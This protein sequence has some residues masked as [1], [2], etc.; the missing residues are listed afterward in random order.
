MHATSIGRWF[1]LGCSLTGL[2]VMTGVAGCA[3]LARSTPS[4]TIEGSATQRRHLAEGGGEDAAWTWGLWAGIDGRFGDPPPVPR[5]EGESR[6]AAARV[7]PRCRVPAACAWE[8]RARSAA[9]DRARAALG[10]GG[11]R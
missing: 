2:A 4:L 1:F 3:E 8:A 11:G 5:R 6:E 7:A 9:M 10:L